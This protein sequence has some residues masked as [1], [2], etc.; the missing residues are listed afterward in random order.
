MAGWRATKMGVLLG[1]TGDAAGLNKLDG[2]TSSQAELNRLDLSAQGGL[3]YWKEEALVLDGVQNDLA[4]TFPTKGYI[5]EVLL[6]VTT[7]DVGETIDLG[8]KVVD[9]DGFLI[10]AS[11]GTIAIVDGPV[12][13]LLPGY[14]CSAATVLTQKVTGVSF[15]AVAKVKVHIT[16]LP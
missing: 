13:A 4:M 5:S 16:E 15:G 10:G 3:D 12:G 8:V 14:E 9:I 1:Y 6:D 2:L 7:A 11:L